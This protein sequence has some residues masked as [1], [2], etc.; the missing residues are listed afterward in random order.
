MFSVVK[1]QSSVA[2]KPKDEQSEGLKQIVR[3]YF[4]SNEKMNYVKDEPDQ[5]TEPQPEE[6]RHGSNHNF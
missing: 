3:E 6:S 1:L 2:K 4:Q 5:A